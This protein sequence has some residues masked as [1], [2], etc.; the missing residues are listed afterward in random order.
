MGKSGIAH[1]LEHMNFNSTKK[2]E[3][4]DFDTIVKNYGGVNNASTG[5]DY[6]KYFINQVVKI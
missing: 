5:F 3:E 1:M 2:L 6:T 4:G